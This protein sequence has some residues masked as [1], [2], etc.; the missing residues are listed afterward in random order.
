MKD[1]SG[2]EKRTPYG[3]ATDVVRNFLVHLAGLDGEAHDGVVARFAEL[4][5]TRVYR[6]ADVMLGETM[7]RSGRSDARDAVA[8]PL[9]QL[10]RIDEPDNSAVPGHRPDDTVD[11]I[12]EPAVAAVLALIVSDLLST[13]TLATLYAPFEPVVPLVS[14]LMSGERRSD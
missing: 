1:R 8:G 12:A 9:L 6:A 13:A 7:A 11:P 4:R 14:V 10:V 5:Q 2:H 3:P